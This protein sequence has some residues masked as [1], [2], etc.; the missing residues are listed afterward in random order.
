[1]ENQFPRFEQRHEGLL[2][3]TPLGSARVHTA[4]SVG[5]VLLPSRQMPGSPLY[6]SGQVPGLLHFRREG[7][8]DLWPKRSSI[9]RSFA[10]D[11]T[12][13]AHEV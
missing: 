8:Q 4:H 2:L 3:L 12:V 9:L 1:M 5:L 11:Q 13:P 10:Q 7:D 6:E